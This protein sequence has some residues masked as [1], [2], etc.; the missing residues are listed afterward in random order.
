VRLYVVLR[1]ASARG[2]HEREVGLGGG[3]LPG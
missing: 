2:V 3:P 1:H